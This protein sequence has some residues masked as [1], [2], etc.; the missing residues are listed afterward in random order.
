MHGRR[1]PLFVMR[2]A[3]RWL[4]L[5]GVAAVVATLARA[6]T[7][8]RMARWGATVVEAD[9]RLPGDEL[10]GDPASTTTRAVTIH[11]P[12]AEVWRWLVQIGTG[13]GGWYT[14][15]WL[16]RLAGVPVR[17]TDE[18]RDEWQHLEVGDRVCLAPPGWMGTPNGMELPV[19]ELIEGASIVLRQQPP[20]SPWEGVWS[21]HVRPVDAGSCR[22]VIR[23]R[24]ATPRGAARVAGEAMAVVM[25]P[26]TFAMERG[27]LLGIKLRAERAVA[28]G[29]RPHA[30]AP[31][32]GG[33]AS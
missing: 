18:V 27:M 6:V 9:Q 2:R 13:R 14:Y 29:P 1:G 3:R 15:D 21:F 12:A 20:D 11:A 31:A 25:D 7:R 24:T 30:A 33:R 5:V 23:S 4:A 8:A 32:S 10:I 28:G 17:N 16:E 19:A 22:L 26:I